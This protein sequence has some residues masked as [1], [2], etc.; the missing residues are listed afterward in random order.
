M[1]INPLSMLFTIPTAPPATA[2]PAAA[3]PAAPPAPPLMPQLTVADFQA[4]INAVDNNGNVNQ[5]KIKAGAADV[6]DARSRIIE[7]YAAEFVL[8]SRIEDPAKMK[9]AADLLLTALNSS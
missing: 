9:E 8:G 5:G 4:Y 3:P 2:P 1:A 6:G 7:G